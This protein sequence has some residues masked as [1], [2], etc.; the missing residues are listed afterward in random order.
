MASGDGTLSPGG[1]TH[2]ALEESALMGRHSRL[3]EI[4]RMAGRRAARCGHCPTKYPW[5]ADS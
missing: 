4:R 2:Y 1:R 3:R 5:R